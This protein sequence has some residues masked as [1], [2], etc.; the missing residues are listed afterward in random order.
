MLRQLRE[1][2]TLANHRLGWALLGIGGLIAVILH[3]WSEYEAM[4]I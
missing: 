1:A 2:L 3:G 4:G